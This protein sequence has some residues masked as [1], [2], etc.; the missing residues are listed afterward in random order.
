MAESPYKTIVQLVLINETGDSYYRMRWPAKDLAFQ[1]PGWRIINLDAQAKERFSWGEAADLLVLYQSNDPDLVPLIE[2]RRRAGKKTLVEYNDNYYEVQPWSP[3]VDAWRSPLLWQRYELLM[4]ISDGVIVTCERLK[5]TLAA[6]VTQRFH[7]LENHL[8]KPPDIIEALRQKK[9]PYVSIGWA[10]SLGHIADLLSIVPVLKRTL[11]RFPEVRLHVMGN[12]T[13]PSLLDIPPDRLSFTNWGTMDQYFHF[14]EEVHIGIAPLL[15]TGYNRCRSDIKA[16][17]MSSMGVLPLVANS[18]PYRRFLEATDIEPFE[19]SEDLES[20]LARF[21][22]D[23]KSREELSA[24]CHAYVNERRIGAKRTERLALYEE[25]MPASATE[26]SFSWPFGPGYYE[27]QG[28]PYPVQMQQGVFEEVNSLYKQGQIDR[29]L[30]K[31]ETFCAEQPFNSDAALT[32]LR[33]LRAARRPEFAQ[34]LQEASFRFPEDLRFSLI[35]VDTAP[36]EAQ[37]ADKWKALFKRLSSLPRQY[38]YFFREDIINLFLRQLQRYPSILDLKSH[39]LAFYPQMARLQ[40]EL[41]ETLRRAGRDAEA[42]EHFS[43]LSELKRL[44]QENRGFLDTIEEKY[45]EAWK[46]ALTARTKE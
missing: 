7:I 43:K 3:I 22:A 28:T 16:V 12:E 27:V 4:K 17:E 41:G 5:E 13:I 39:I 2:K 30:Q 14:W 10:A 21:I 29:A 37:A 38:G 33:C 36:N 32:R 26:N 31:I 1:A 34:Q 45:I 24:K 20:L 9:T 15:D 8:P 40:F 25:M 23:G 42:L 46:T 6:H 11:A 44:Y 19:S 18:P 35:A